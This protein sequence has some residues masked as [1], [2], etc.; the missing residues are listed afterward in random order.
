[1]TMGDHENRT[2]IDGVIVAGP[3]NSIVHDRSK[4]STAVCRCAT[5]NPIG[6]ITDALHGGSSVCRARVCPGP[7]KI[8]VEVPNR[9]ITP[10]DE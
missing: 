7:S 2:R 6:S 9:A 5:E 4:S 3:I 8:F 10:H 1:M